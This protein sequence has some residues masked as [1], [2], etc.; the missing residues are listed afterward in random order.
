MIIE[1]TTEKDIDALEKMYYEVTAQLEETVNYPAWINGLYPTRET[2]EEAVSKGAMYVARTEDG[3]DGKIAAG[4]VLKSEEEPGFCD[5]EWQI[6]A[7]ASEIYVLCTLAVALD[8][9][10]CGLGEEMVRFAIKL[11]K[12][13]GKKAVRLDVTEINA[14]AISL[15]EKLG[16]KYIDIMDTGEE[17]MLEY[18]Q[19]IFR[20]YEK[21]I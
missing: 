20:L 15:Y 13:S 10:G 17:Y 14:P 8:F 9:N 18:G 21:L 4:M 1:K 5:I 11:A 2:F 16:F 3:E 12:E 6:E 7:E 19:R